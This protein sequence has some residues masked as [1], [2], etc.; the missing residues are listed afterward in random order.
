MKNILVAGLNPAWQK[1]LT[2]EK[3]RRG[4]VNRAK[5]CN[6]TAS[7]K[8][9]NFARAARN[10]GQA[11][12]NVFQF[13]SGNA[14]ESIREELDRT[15]YRHT[16]VYTPGETRTCTTVLSEDDCS[17]TELIAPSPIIP[18]DKT[19][20]LRTA[21]LAAIPDADGVA[22]CGTV[23][24]GVGEDFYGAIAAE[25]KKHGKM[26]LLDSVCCIN[27]AL[28]AGVSVLKINLD[29]LRGI[30][31]KED[32]ECAMTECFNKYNVQYLAITDGPG[33]AYFSD[34][35]ILTAYNI[36]VLEKIVSPLGCGDTCSA[37]MLSCMV[38]GM[39]PAESFRNGLAA[40]CANCLNSHPA[41]FD[42]A[43]ALKLL[44]SITTE[45]IADA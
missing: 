33:H 37:V 17:M 19:E 5:S 41:T 26:L 11:K 8:G 24:P 28:K 34:G 27:E 21:F 13:L 44:E 9:I 2:F 12:A 4:T 18:A 42:K 20:E 10:W 45:R 25:A 30:T 29:E 7:G 32:A 3:F 40:A 38:S 22:L 36:P 35:K 43:E 16:T 15:G 1:T 23:P 31:E 14:G 39:E 6:H